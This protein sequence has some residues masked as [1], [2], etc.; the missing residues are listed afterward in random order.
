MLK[1]NR[2]FFMVVAFAPLMLPSMAQAGTHRDDCLHKV[3]RDADRV[4]QHVA[5]DVDRGLHRLFKWCDR[6]HR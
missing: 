2:S 5:K 4:V 1:N 3:F 6:R